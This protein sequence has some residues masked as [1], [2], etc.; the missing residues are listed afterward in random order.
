MLTDGLSALAFGAE[1]AES[2]VM[3]RAANENVFAH[4]MWQH[5]VWIGFFV[6]GITLVNDLGNLS[7]RRTLADH[8]F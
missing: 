7:R 3:Q 8:R 5:I 1:P 2:N 4:G 6:G